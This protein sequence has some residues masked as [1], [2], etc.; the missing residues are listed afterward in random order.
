M[1]W[2][3]I[4]LKIH[5]ATM[6]I[7]YKRFWNCG[8]FPS[9]FFNK[10]RKLKFTWKKNW[11]Y[12]TTLASLEIVATSKK[13]WTPND[14]CYSCC[15]STIVAVYSNLYV[16]PSIAMVLLLIYYELHLLLYIALLLLPPLMNCWT[17]SASTF[18][19]ALLLQL[20]CYCYW[21]YFILLLLPPLTTHQFFKA[22]KLWRN[23]Q[24]KFLTI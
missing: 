4:F 19:C 8:G 11:S 13:S 6:S 18:A 7:P 22:T 16:V 17:P 15:C 20:Y 9:A 12:L 24:Q 1:F 23:K 5:M 14:F 3:H 10:I 21:C 2:Y